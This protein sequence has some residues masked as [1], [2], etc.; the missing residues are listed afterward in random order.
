MLLLQDMQKASVVREKNET[1][2]AKSQQASL[3]LGEGV[4]LFFF[5]LYNAK[6]HRDIS[7]LNFTAL[8]SLHP[9]L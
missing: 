3:N 9:E 6:D 4:H 2:D 1:D 8:E 5:F 7:S